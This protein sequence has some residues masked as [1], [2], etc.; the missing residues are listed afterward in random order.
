MALYPLKDK[1]REQ[2]GAFSPLTELLGGLP[3]MRFWNVQLKPGATYPAVVVRILADPQPYAF[4]GP[5]P[6][7]FT[8]CELVAWDTNPQR[9]EQLDSAIQDFIA[10]F[11]GGGLP[12]AP[13]PNAAPAQ[14]NRILNR[15]DGFFPAPQQP[16]YMR[17]FTAEFWNNP[18]VP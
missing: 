1:L 17:I 9:L 2:A 3:T 18:S 11:N 7:S 12:V 15:R 6:A 14:G 16:Q 4:P 5:L 10:A 8:V 13:A